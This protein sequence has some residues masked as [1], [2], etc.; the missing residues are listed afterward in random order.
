MRYDWSNAVAKIKNHH[1]LNIRMSGNYYWKRGA[2]PAMKFVSLL[3]TSIA[4][5]N[6]GDQVIMEA[7]EK[8]LLELLHGS[9][10]TK[11]QTHDVISKVSHNILKQSQFKIVGGTNLLSSNMD[12]F[13]QWKINQN[14]VPYLENV[15]LMG[16]GWWNYQNKPNLYTTKLYRKILSKRYLHS[17]RDSYT[18]KQLRSIGITNV[19]NTGCPSMWELTS[20][21][22]NDIPKSRS[23]NVVM[24]LTEGRKNFHFDRKLYEILKDQYEKVYFWTQQA[25]DYDYMNSIAGGNVTYV[26]PTLRSFDQLLSSTKIDY[27]GTRLHGGIRALQHKRRTLILSVDNRASEIAK[28]TNLPVLERTNLDAIKQWTNNPFV[29]QIKLREPAI[30]RWKDQ[31]KPINKSK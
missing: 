14:N 4:S 12:R 10:F 2:L 28:D 18:E 16:V 3:D 22:C 7:V 20:S 19:I 6:L 26:A 5:T 31:F 9:F 11:I 29:T 21:H 17:V 15:I 25:L 30:Q 24:T 1:I 13:N 27:V 23:Q 8:V